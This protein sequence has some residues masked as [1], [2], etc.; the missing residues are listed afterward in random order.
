MA[1][2]A[3]SGGQDPAA[4]KKAIKKFLAVAIKVTERLTADLHAAGVPKVEHG[5]A[6][7]AAF[8]K[9]VTRTRGAYVAARRAA[10]GLPTGDP[11]AFTAAVQQLL[12]KLQAAGAEL[13]T[14]LAPIERADPA[15]AL[16]KAFAR[17]PACTSSTRS[18]T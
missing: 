13:E 3:S 10:A 16:G 14:A 15:S 8:T 9:A 18:E 5:T 7:A 17:A 1:Q 4:R 6:I 12:T 11:A 2:A